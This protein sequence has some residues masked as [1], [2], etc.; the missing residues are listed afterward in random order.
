MPAIIAALLVLLVL[1]A[2]ASA[3][4]IWIK[5]GAPRLSEDELRRVEK[6]LAA[7]ERALDTENRIG[8]HSAYGRVPDTLPR[9]DA[10]ARIS[11]SDTFDYKILLV[12]AQAIRAAGGICDTISGAWEAGWPGDSVHNYVLRCD[13]DTKMYQLFPSGQYRTTPEIRF[14]RLR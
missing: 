2:H 4:Q 8:Y 9:L 11:W 10:R 1:P 7:K 3:D 6:E 13:S 14:R 12:V 5:E